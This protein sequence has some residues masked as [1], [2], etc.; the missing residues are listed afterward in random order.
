MNS[1]KYLEGFCHIDN[2]VIRRDFLEDVRYQIQ[3]SLCVRDPSNYFNV[4]VL[5]LSEKLSKGS[6]GSVIYHHIMYIIE[7]FHSRLRN[8]GKISYESD[9]MEG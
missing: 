9:Q 1:F 7:V 5:I 3:E 8:H 4:I 6:V 2:A